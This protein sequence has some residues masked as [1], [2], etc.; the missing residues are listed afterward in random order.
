MKKIV[1]YTTFS[2]LL[3]ASLF[4]AVSVSAINFPRFDVDTNFEERFSPRY[5]QLFQEQ[6]SMINA[7][8][9]EVVTALVDGKDLLT[10]A[11]EKGMTEDQ[12]DE[13]M[14]AKRDAQAKSNLDSLVSRG[15][16]TQAQADKRINLVKSRPVKK[17]TKDTIRE[18][19][20]N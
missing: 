2:S 17:T 19:K 20:N 8:I 11:K 4:G 13:K 9:D 15:L 10:L 3:G 1:I 12:F 14:K 5:T 18:R 6:A 7:T 16:I